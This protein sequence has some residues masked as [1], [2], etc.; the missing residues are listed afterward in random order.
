MLF[1]RMDVRPIL[2]C[3]AGKELEVAVAVSCSQLAIILR[4]PAGFS[5]P[6]D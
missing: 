6:E 2:R 5:S 4:S 3:D 1:G